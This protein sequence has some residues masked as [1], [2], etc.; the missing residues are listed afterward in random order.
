MSHLGI[1]PFSPVSFRS[2]VQKKVTMDGRVLRVEWDT[3]K[4]ARDKEEAE[5]AALL[6]KNV[7]VGNVPLD[8]TTEELTAIFEPFGELEKVVLAGQTSS[9]ANRKDFAFVNFKERAHALA[10]VE[11]QSRKGPEDVLVPP[12][13]C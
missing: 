12:V 11:G 5:K 9:S 13:S 1:S 7:F 4:E 6:V 2:G 10:A 3:T 8:V